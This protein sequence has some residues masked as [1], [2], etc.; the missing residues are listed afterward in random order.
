MKKVIQTILFISKLAWKNMKL[1]IFLRLFRSIVSAVVPVINILLSKYIVDE[2]VNGQDLKKLITYVAIVIGLT[3]FSAA[4]SSYIGPRSFVLRGK[5]YYMILEEMS[6]HAASL[7]YEFLENPEILNLKQRAWKCLSSGGSGV[8]K[9]LEEVFDLIAQF[10][11]LCGILAIIFTLSPWIIVLLFVIVGA[12]ALLSAKTNKKKFEFNKKKVPYDRKSGY[13]SHLME[14]FA[15]GKEIRLWNLGD[16][17]LGKMN[18]ANAES[19]AWYAKEMMCNAKDGVF[20]SFTGLIQQGAMY[21]YL[22]YAIIVQGMTI[23]SFT[24]YFSAI[25]SF[26]GTLQKFADYY[27]NVREMAMYLDDYKKYMELPCRSK[28][29]ATLVPEL[30]KDSVIE[31]CSVSF[32]YSGSKTPAVTDL[33]VRIPIGQ[34]LSL[35]GANG[36]GKTTFVKLLTRLYDPTEGQ[37]LLDGTDIREFNYAEWLKLF[38]PVFQDYRLFSTTLEENIKLGIEDSDETVEG[39]VEKA[40]LQEKFNSLPNGFQTHLFKKFNDDA[41][42]LSGGESQKLAI[43]RALYKNSPIVILDEPTAALDPLSEYDIYTR[44]GQLIGGKTVVFVT[45]RLGSVQFCDRI[46]AFDKGKIIEDG[47]HQELLKEQKLYSEMWKH[48]AS[49]YEKEKSTKN[50]MAENN[51]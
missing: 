15:Y 1:W 26:S 44:F 21:A 23:G 49:F 6:V 36:A 13:W 2:L 48:Q 46:L 9:V 37:I 42:E 3:F 14:D 7:D 39:C 27:T 16:F 30:K 43:A 51:V 47:T 41:I 34:K 17:L 35:V 11:A 25:T 40:G 20:R 33:N 24:M 4:V 29:P 12:N 22:I 18:K 50:E 28:S 32:T 5:L 10:I 31:F 45:H 38:A 19:N 8:L